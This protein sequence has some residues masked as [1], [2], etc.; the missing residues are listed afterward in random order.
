MR[1]RNKEGEMTQMGVVKSASHR[2]THGH[3]L[4]MRTDL[5]E[6]QRR[7]LTGKVHLV[8]LRD[9]GQVLFDLRGI[10]ASDAQLGEQLRD[11]ENVA[12]ARVC[13]IEEPL[14]SRQC[15]DTDTDTDTQTHR[16]GHRHGHRHTDTDTDTQTHTDTHF[17]VDKAVAVLE[18]VLVEGQ[19]KMH[20]KAFGDLLRTQHVRQSV[21][22]R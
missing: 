10:D 1:A 6:R 5:V 4:K 2:Y 19:P 7:I 14:T 20:L 11:C 12:H 8:L 15:T 17:D 3:T 22:K 16:H 18:R 13:V 9:D 21:E